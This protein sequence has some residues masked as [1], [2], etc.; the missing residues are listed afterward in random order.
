MYS[1]FGI[2][3]TSALLLCVFAVQVNAEEQ[4]NNPVEVM[5]L[6]V[7]SSNG[8]TLYDGI[9]DYV[10]LGVDNIGIEGRLCVIFGDLMHEK[11][12][13]TIDVFTVHLVSDRQQ[14]EDR[15]ARTDLHVRSRTTQHHLGHTLLS[16]SRTLKCRRWFKPLPKQG[17]SGES[18][19]AGRIGNIWHIMPFI[20]T[21]KKLA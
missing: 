16:P 17:N 20:K 7:G 8:P 18:V 6:V 13:P 12:G 3:I 5:G 10:L 1:F 9:R 15:K 11:N 14:Q 19:A 21:P 2:F 4:P